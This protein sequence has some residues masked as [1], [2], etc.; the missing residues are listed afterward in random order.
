MS[1]GRGRRRIDRAAECGEPDSFL[2]ALCR[3]ESRSLVLRGEAGVG[4]SALLEYLTGR[5]ADRR[6][7]SI[8][9]LQSEMEL[10]EVFSVGCAIV[11]RTIER[12]RTYA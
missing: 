10:M 7:I 6:I 2:Q 5:A 11:Y 1:R 12:L 4:K 9:V 3:G 8:R